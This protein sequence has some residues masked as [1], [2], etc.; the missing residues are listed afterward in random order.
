[1]SQADNRNSRSPNQKKRESI[2]SNA[3]SYLI[4]SKKILIYLIHKIF[5]YVFHLTVIKF[6]GK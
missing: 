2:G 3:S 4:V 1:M 5:N 6:I